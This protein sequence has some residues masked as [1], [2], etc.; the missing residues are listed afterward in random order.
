[1]GKRW[2]LV[3]AA[4]AATLTVYAT[5]S[6]AAAPT[7][8]VER[9]STAETWHVFADVGKKDNGGPADIYV[10]QQTLR[11][12]DGTPVGEINGYGVNL[13]PPYVFFHWTASLPGGSLTVEGAVDV[14]RKTAVYAIEG[15][16]GRYS[17][18]R[19]TVT[20]ADTARKGTLVTVRFNRQPTAG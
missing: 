12:P 7:A 13:H 4:F 8:T 15:G 1:M 11:T 5:A 9:Y 3:P 14:S 16:T 17:G 6:T 20:V 19:G 10:A 2:L 18:A